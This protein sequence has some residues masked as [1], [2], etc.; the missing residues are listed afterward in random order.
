MRGWGC[1]SGP[2]YQDAALA[3]INRSNLRCQ[4]IADIVATTFPTPTSLSSTTTRRE[5]KRFDFCYW[6]CLCHPDLQYEPN[7][8][9]AILANLCGCNASV[10]IIL[11]KI[12]K[13]EKLCYRKRDGLRFLDTLR[14]GMA[15]I[16]ESYDHRCRIFSQ[17]RYVPRAVFRLFLEVLHCD[18]TRRGVQGLY[19]C[20]S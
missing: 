14:P 8:N 3:D 6:L 2:S 16:I 9:L 1:G 19:D 11:I 15:N 18:N 20:A 17:P 12:I 10:R 5:D 13:H 7:R 4:D